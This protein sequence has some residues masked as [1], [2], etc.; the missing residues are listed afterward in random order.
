M[1]KAYAQVFCDN[2]RF[3]YKAIPEVSTPVATLNSQAMMYLD[4]FRLFFNGSQVPHST[5]KP[6]IIHGSD[7]HGDSVRVQRMADFAD[8]IGAAEVCLTGDLIPSIAISGYSYLHEIVN[9]AKSQFVISTGNHDA[10]DTGISN[11]A[12]YERLFAPMASKLKMTNTDKSWYYYDD[13]KNKLRF[14][15]LDECNEGRAGGHYAY[16][17]QDQADFLIDALQTVP[18]EYGVFL[19]YHSPEH[20]PS[21]AGDHTGYDKFFATIRPYN[22][23]LSGY[24]GTPYEDVIDAFIGRTTIDKTYTQSAASGYDTTFTLQGDFSSVPSSVEFIAHLCGHMHIDGVYYIKNKAHK[25]LMLDVPCTTG[26]SGYSAYSGWADLSD[27]PRHPASA[28]Q[29]CFNAYV[30]D[31]AIKTVHVIRI[32]ANFPYNRQIRDYMSIPYAD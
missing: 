15:S 23:R 13:T 31:R 12:Q 24:S 25:Q 29:D 30:I 1:T 3:Q 21:T 28:T 14:I 16:C 27:F 18:A 8:A 20:V 9:N 26:L 10:S 7:T 17:C 22:A 6:V 4:S 11:A 19:L 32:G 5:V 2:L